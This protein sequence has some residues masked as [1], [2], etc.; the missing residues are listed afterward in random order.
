M[1]IHD[2]ELKCSAV[3]LPGKSSAV[4]NL[5]QNPSQRPIV[6]SLLPTLMRG[7]GAM[8]LI[9]NPEKPPENE[10]DATVEER[11]MT[12][13]ARLNGRGRLQAASG[14]CAGLCI[15]SLCLMFSDCFLMFFDVQ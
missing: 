14:T 6:S 9:F 2:I 15:M 13:K 10:G 1:E 3:T 5:T 11:W 8:F 7:C 12:P 4:C